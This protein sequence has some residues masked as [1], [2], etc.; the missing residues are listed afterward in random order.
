MQAL[1]TANM[2]KYI[3]TVRLKLM[4]P[5]LSITA[6]RTFLR[7]LLR[8]SQ[9]ITSSQFYRL[10]HT[11]EEPSRRF[12]VQPCVASEHP[13][14]NAAAVSS[15]PQTSAAP[16][17]KRPPRKHTKISTSAPAGGRTKKPPS[18]AW[19]LDAARSTKRRTRRRGN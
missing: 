9:F 15:Q 6:S 7:Q 18:P 14:T 17:C 3:Y 8:H 10:R 12:V 19:S 13:P 4:N 2:S 11:Q 16:N 1:R 5:P